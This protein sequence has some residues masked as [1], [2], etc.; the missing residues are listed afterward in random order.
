MR[1]SPTH[2]RMPI[3]QLEFDSIDRIA[4]R[5]VHMFPGRREHEDI[6]MDLTACVLG[7]CELRLEELEVAD[8]LNFAHDLVGIERHLN[9]QTFQLEDCFVPRF[10]RGRSINR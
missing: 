10:A 2:K 4:N 8:D 7:G 5:A 9:R 3:T 1:R 6:K